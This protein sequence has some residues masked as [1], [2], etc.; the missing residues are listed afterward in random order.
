MPTYTK[1]PSGMI[2]SD[3]T[4]GAVTYSQC[5]TGGGNRCRCGTCRICGF[6][7]HTAI[8]GPGCDD[9]RPGTRPCGHVFAG[10]ET[11]TN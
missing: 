4:S 9:P 2:L 7:K 5:P 10:P 11:A 8:H 1:S 6:H 3:E